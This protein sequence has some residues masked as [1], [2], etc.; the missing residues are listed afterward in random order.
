MHQSTAVP[1]GFEFCPRILPISFLSDYCTAESCSHM[2]SGQCGRVQNTA[3]FPC[4]LHKLP[5][6][7]TPKRRLTPWCP[8][9]PPATAALAIQNGPWTVCWAVDGICSAFLNLRISSLNTSRVADRQ[10]WSAAF[11]PFR[12]RPADCCILRTSTSM[13]ASTDTATAGDTSAAYVIVEDGS[14]RLLRNADAL[15]LSKDVVARSTLLSDIQAST[16]DGCSAKLP[17]SVEA[18]RAWT[19]AAAEPSSTSSLSAQ[20]LANVLVVRVRSLCSKHIIPLHSS[21]L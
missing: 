19:A 8:A 15:V 1:W 20:Q 2:L 12:P 5:W 10:R 21:V 9:A 13:A 16:S 7:A 18:V 17:I 6:P 11:R 3:S 14:I 4:W